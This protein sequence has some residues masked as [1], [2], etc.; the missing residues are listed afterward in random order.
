MS[1]RMRTCGILNCLCHADKQARHRPYITYW[2]AKLK[3][4]STAMLIR[5]DRLTDVRGYLE[6]YQQFL[7]IIDGLTA[8]S[9]R[10]ILKRI[11]KAK[12]QS[13]Q[14]KKK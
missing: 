14:N 1:K 7:G 13:K 10:I 9:S 4:Q 12:K 8:L 6:N 5:A 11:E 3:G 2:S